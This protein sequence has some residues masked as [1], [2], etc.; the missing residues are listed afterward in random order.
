MSCDARRRRRGTRG[1]EIE[2]SHGSA[3]DRSAPIAPD[4]DDAD[5]GGPRRFV[6]AVSFVPPAAVGV[7][8]RSATGR[9]GAEEDG[10]RW[11]RRT[12]ADVGECAGGGIIFFVAAVRDRENESLFFWVEKAPK[13]L[14]TVS[15]RGL[16]EGIYGMV[17]YWFQQRSTC[18]GSD[19]FHFWL[20][21]LLTPS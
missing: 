16:K 3:A 8:R 4:V 2:R 6:A 21:S 5:G 12:S 15:Q 14:N 20:N 7:S 17:Y 13:Y 19:F 10:G 11:R 1:R 18:V 9:G